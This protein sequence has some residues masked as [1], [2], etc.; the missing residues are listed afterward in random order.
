MIERWR[1]IETAPKERD[2][3]LWL[4]RLQLMMLGQIAPGWFNCGR[5]AGSGHAL[6]APPSHWIPLPDPP[7]PDGA[8]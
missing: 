1:P 6:P 3:L 7:P 5:R 8:K 4:P 2:L